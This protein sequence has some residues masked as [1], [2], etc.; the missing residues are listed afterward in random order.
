[1]KL[2]LYPSAIILFLSLSACNALQALGT[3]PVSQNSQSENTIIAK[4]QGTTSI[5]AS[6][7]T[8][9]PGKESKP[10]EVNPGSQN[11]NT[12]P[13]ST[14]SNLPPVAENNS[15]ITTAPEQAARQNETGEKNAKMPPFP[16]DIWERL[17]QGYKLKDYEHQRVQT[18]LAWYTRHPEYIER[19][20]ERAEPFLHWIL[21]EVEKR[22]LPS[23]IALLPIV[24]SAFQPFAYSHGRASGIWQFIPGT[25]KRFGLKQN[26]WYDGRRDVVASTQAALDYLDYLQQQFNGD[27]L[28][29]LAAYNSGEGTVQ[30]AIR[31][32]S[33]RGKPVDFWNLDLPPETRS[34][35]PK[36]LAISALF[37]KPANF[38]ITLRFIPNEARITTVDV[39]SQIDLALAADLAKMSLEDMYKLNPGYNRWATDPTGP[40]QL[41][42]PLDQEVLFRENLAR[43]PEDRRIKWKRHKIGNGEAISMIAKRYHTTVDLLR[44]VNGLR[45]NQ[46]RAGRYLI[47]P[48]ASLSLQQY[49]LSLQ[50]RKKA[51]LSQN[52]TGRKIIHEVAAGDTFWDLSIKYRVNVNQLARWNG[53]APAD[54]LKTGQ[55]L[56]IWVKQSKQSSAV[57]SRVSFSLPAATVRPIRYVVKPGDSLA[58]IS[59]RF[60][61][62]IQQLKNWNNLKGQKYLQP[63]QT[64]KLFVDVTQQT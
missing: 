63:G 29:A 6:Q 7:V 8:P 4:R 44:K 20:T 16:I 32:N 35:V 51:L 24:E 39:G 18:E 12:L 19:V 17:R 10:A 3:R 59:E 13:T 42:I 60:N 55:K 57:I 62:S 58:R 46:I 30:R 27:W 31:K 43:L 40:H 38:N 49:T 22:K 25:G 26:W 5:E 64:L 48:V 50:Q 56:V 54:T 41:V 53:M 37:E 45:N 23:E 14:T 52:H 9:D 47:I 61:V 2:L 34:Y 11:Q 15:N 33:A 1:M 36:L 21:G 28:L